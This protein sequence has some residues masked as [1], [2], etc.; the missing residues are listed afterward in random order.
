MINCIFMTVVYERSLP[1]PKWELMTEKNSTC[2]KLLITGKVSEC[3]QQF[4]CNMHIC[5]SSIFAVKAP[6]M[7]S[8]ENKDE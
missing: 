1:A 4:S 5:L 7:I 3:R 8:M 2:F 6:L